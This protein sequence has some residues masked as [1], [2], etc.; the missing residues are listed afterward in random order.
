MRRESYRLCIPTSRFGAS[1]HNLRLRMNT[2]T[3]RHSGQ[4]AKL[5]LALTLTLACSDTLAACAATHSQANP[6]KTIHADNTK[7]LHDF[8]I[9]FSGLVDQMQARV[10]AGERAE[11]G[12]DDTQAR[13][14]APATSS[15]AA[16]NALL[17]PASRRTIRAAANYE[18][19]CTKRHKTPPNTK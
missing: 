5:A 15:T 17:S 18:N 16:R 7:T 13:A 14:L 8:A 4:S 19:K 1:I 6:V 11:F 10:T 9:G 3:G 2:R 12:Y